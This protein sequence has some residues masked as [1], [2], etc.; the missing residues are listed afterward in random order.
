MKLRGV[1]FSLSAAFD[2]MLFLKI[3]EISGWALI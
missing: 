3:T 2:A 1:G